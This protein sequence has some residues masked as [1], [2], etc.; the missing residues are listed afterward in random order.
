ML[1]VPS[2]IV[3][4]WST[5]CLLPVTVMAQSIGGSLNLPTVEGPTFRAV[6]GRVTDVKG[7]PVGGAGVEVLTNAGA[8]DYHSFIT[9]PEGRFHYD[10]T[11]FRY[12]ATEFIALVTVSKKGY[13]KAHA[14]ANY[15]ASGKPYE[16][17]IVLR[18]AQNDPT[19]LSQA[20]LV[21]GLT[22]K[23][24]HLDTSDGLSAKES[25]TYDRGVAEFLDRNRLDLAVP[26][27]EK[28]VASN[29]ACLRCRVMLALADM[30]WGD[31]VNAERHLGEAVNA[32]IANRKLGIAEP[33]LAYGV[34]VS[35]QH[36]P[37][38]AEPYLREAVKDAPQ[39]ALALQELGR[40]QC[41]TMNWEGAE[42]TLKKALAAGAGPEARLLHAQAL[43]WA[44]TVNDAD[45]ELK[46]YLDGRD[47]KKMSPRVQEVGE[48]IQDR[49]KDDRA[50]VKLQKRT[51]TYVDYLHNP[52]P[53]LE[54]IEPAGDQVKLDTLLSAV[55]G[56]V[57]ELFHKFPNTSSLEKIHQEKLD[58]KGKSAGSLNQKFRYLCLIPTS[59]WG[60]AT[61]E[62]RAD[63]TGHAAYLRGL[64]ENYMLTSGFVAAPLVFHPTYQPGSV[65]RLLG[66]QKIK[67]RDAYLIAFAQE[68]KR[69]RMY[70]TFKCD[71]KTRETFYQGVAWIDSLSYQILRLRTELL[72]P[73][74]VV[75]LQAETTE[76]EF[77]EV[78][79]KRL[80]EGF[81][82]PAKV[83][84]TLDWEGRT[85]RNQ[86]EYSDFVVFNVDS[87][88]KIGKPKGAPPD[89]AENLAP[90]ATP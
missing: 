62:Y 46:Q 6:S 58:R 31:S 29:P 32:V 44:G 20:D 2:R 43:V 83:T 86:H 60:P 11:F 59:Q 70:G 30:S 19:L 73:L 37:D 78:H 45:A 38:K 7:E 8:D 40:I 81:W 35:W 84:V 39:D 15:G 85:L 56:N 48:K 89:S 57:A 28:L 71:G 18:P 3:L 63:S 53:D 17:P 51:T 14:Y 13:P 4:L 90:K 49:K 34:W 26:L 5:L 27:F 82:L 88:E 33:L 87:M 36:N 61:D 66:R 79:F 74:P 52:P 23:L 16:I 64:S 50:L 21:S 24:R 67:G 75:K 9:N 41:L 10:Y 42:E 25:K 69:S 1:Q 77:S 22:P 54:K 68:P 72:T 55:G 12:T 47:I 65:F 80:E 76:I